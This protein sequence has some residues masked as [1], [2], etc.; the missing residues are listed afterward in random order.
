MFKNISKYSWFSFVPFVALA[1]LTVCLFIAGAIPLAY[2]WLTL[3]GWVLTA[4][5]GVAV[6]YH[7]VFA[8]NNYSNLPRWK[9]NFIL[10]WGTMS[11]QGSAITWTAIHR[12]YHHKHS[13][14]DR[15]IHS[16]VHGYY[17]AFFGWATKITEESNVIN[18]KYAANL[19][20]K[21]NIIWFHENQ[22]NILWLT[23]II[24][25]IFFGWQVA[26]ALFVLP[27]GLTLLQDNLVN[28]FGHL[29]AGIGYR[30]F[31]TGDRSQ[32]NIILGYLCWGQ[33][34]HN[35]HHYAPD[36]FN[37]GSGISGKWWEFDACVIFL[38][39]LKSK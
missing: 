27:T 3:V 8:H 15:D 12:G 32:N 36:S 24:T 2:L 38:P 37:F 20:R 5:L 4:G 10:F 9:E 29:R 33:G 25:A 34:W 13:D 39:F 7:R 17:H 16:P 31:E 21:K 1:L 22:M 11:G 6:G 26:L 28:V 19:L 35:N 14:T 30:N 18:L 23:P